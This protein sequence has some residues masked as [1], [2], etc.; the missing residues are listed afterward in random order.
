M[1]S[2]ERHHADE[3][4]KSLAE[5]REHTLY[6][7]EENEELGMLAALNQ[8]RIDETKQQLEQPV[9]AGGWLAVRWW[10]SAMG[11][12]RVAASQLSSSC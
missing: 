6:L 11:G 3:L 2:V 9:V 1:V 4:R 12:W 7:E 8:R 10:G 5:V